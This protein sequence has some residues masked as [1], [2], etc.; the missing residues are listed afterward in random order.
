M[1]KNKTIGKTT[2]SKNFSNPQNVAL[3]K[4]LL[5]SAILFYYFRYCSFENAL[6][7]TN[8]NL[9]FIK[10]QLVTTNNDEFLARD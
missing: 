7:R 6:V 2:K 10:K 5:I 8:F 4:S 1:Q 9:V 3:R